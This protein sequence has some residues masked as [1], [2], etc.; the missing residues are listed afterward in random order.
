MNCDS[1][2]TLLRLTE[3]KV[4]VTINYILVGNFKQKINTFVNLP[5][6]IIT[7]NSG[8]SIFVFYKISTKYV[9]WLHL[10]ESMNF[11]IKS[12]NNL[13]TR[14]LPDELVT[15]LNKR[16]PINDWLIDNAVHSVKHGKFLYSPS[17]SYFPRLY[18]TFKH[19]TLYFI[20]VFV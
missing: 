10:I 16:K 17:L 2:T 12:T 9:L 15:D 4:F 18:V 1:F 14:R 8:N 6:S 7:D 13:H 5:L 3:A 19:S 11:I 20:N